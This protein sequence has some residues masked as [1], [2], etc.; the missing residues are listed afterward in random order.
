MLLFSS[1]VVLL[2]VVII[3]D[4]NGAL[5]K[6]VCDREG[7]ELLVYLSS[8]TFFSYALLDYSLWLIT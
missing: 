6:F 3:S 7:L 2:V 1:I 4:G 8:G 5:G